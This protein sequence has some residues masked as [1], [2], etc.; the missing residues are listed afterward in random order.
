VFENLMD[1]PA[2]VKEARSALE[3]LT[4]GQPG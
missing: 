1:G 3:A 2:H 4:A